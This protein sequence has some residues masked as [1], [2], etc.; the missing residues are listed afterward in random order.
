MRPSTITA[1]FLVKFFIP[2]TKI[3]LPK[4]LR[5]RTLSDRS[6]TKLIGYS[7][8]ILLKLIFLKIS[9]ENIKYAS[10]SPVKPAPIDKIARMIK[11]GPSGK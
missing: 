7:K 10:S 2:E 3:E 6:F 8:L 1:T 4:L 11:V 5:Y 9:N